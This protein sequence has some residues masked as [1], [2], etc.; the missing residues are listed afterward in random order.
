MI[1]RLNKGGVVGLIVLLTLM[2]I[3]GCREWNSVPTVVDQSLGKAYHAMVKSQTLCTEHGLKAKDPKLCPG[4]GPV[5]AMDGQ[6]AKGV[7]DAYR[8][9]S[10]QATEEAKKGVTFEVKNVGGSSN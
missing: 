2:M 6:K 7:I 3:T 8:Q 5:M 10:T 9:G 4:H 1:Q